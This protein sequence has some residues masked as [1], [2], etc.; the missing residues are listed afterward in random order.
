[1]LINMKNRVDE[2]GI[3][4]LLEFALG[5]GADKLKATVEVYRTSRVLE[6]YGCVSEDHLVGIIGCA[7]RPDNQLEITHL[8]VHPDSRGA[9]FGRGIILELIEI[10]QPA[11]LIAE[12]DEEAVDFY[13]SIGFTIVSLG[14]KY[15]GVERFECKYEVDQESD[16]D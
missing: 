12:T 16:E 4:E 9:G 5:Q 8:A 6:L 13:R 10:K 1:M 11:S 7:E 3:Q 14:E 15:P 2:E